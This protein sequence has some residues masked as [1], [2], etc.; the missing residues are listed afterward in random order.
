[1]PRGAVAIGGGLESLRSLT[2]PS[3]HPAVPSPPATCN[4][5]FSISTAFKSLLS[6]IIE[7]IK[8]IEKT[9]NKKALDPEKYSCCF[10]L[11]S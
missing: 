7:T 11:D 6:Q 9:L 5:H 4:S 1:V 2:T 3:S 10:L 8:Y